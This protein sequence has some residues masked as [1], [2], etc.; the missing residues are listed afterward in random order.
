MD[1]GS[2]RL[3]WTRLKPDGENELIPYAQFKHFYY[4]EYLNSEHWRKVRVQCLLWFGGICWECGE[5][6]AVI[7]HHSRKAY[8]KLW[9]ED[10]KR[11]LVPICRECHD[12]R[13]SSYTKPEIVVKKEYSRTSNFDVSTVREVKKKRVEKRI[14]SRTESVVNNYVTP[15]RKRVE[16]RY[17]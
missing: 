6:G 16:K 2:G 4:D 14:A 7:V 1:R 11:D 3:V 5:K 8:K 9:Q 13:H 17:G 12:G 10:P 15:K